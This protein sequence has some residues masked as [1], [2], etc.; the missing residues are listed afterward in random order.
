MGFYLVT[1]VMGGGK[2]MLCAD[3]M[4]TALSEGAVVH[5]NIALNQ[6]IIDEKGWTELYV[7][8]PEDSDLWRSLLRKG[9]EGAEN[10]LVVDEASLAFHVHDQQK[11]RDANRGIFELLVWSRRAGLDVYFVSQS[12]QNLDSQLRRLTE[13]RY[14]CT[15]V[16]MIPFIG[17]WMKY[18]V[19]DFMR[20]RYAGGDSKSRIGTT[21]HRFDQR[22]ADF[23]NTHDMHGRELGIQ[24]GGPTR[25]RKKN[26]DART[27]GCVFI[28]LIAAAIFGAWR[29][30]GMF[31]GRDDAQAPPEASSAPAGDSPAPVQPQELIKKL[32]PEP[33]SFAPRVFTVAVGDKVMEWAVDSS[34]DLLISAQMQEPLRLFLRGGGVLQLGQP[35]EG[36]QVQ[37]IVTAH[38]R[39]YILCASGRKLVARQPTRKEQAEWKAISNT[40][41][42]WSSWGSAP[43]PGSG[44]ESK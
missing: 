6:A 5:T 27:M 25:T 11:R 24:D 2:S 22:I 14:H 44:S 32:Q 15:Q 39:Y 7:K 18:L 38:Q 8:L 41:R 9:A 28:F 29:F 42:S 10:L 13:I 16:K 40:R 30:Y 43:V 34:D 17:P 35:Y 21:Y 26:K 12:A 31:W 19:G 1:G 20:T 33:S 23:Y 36:D 37:S 3:I 4:R